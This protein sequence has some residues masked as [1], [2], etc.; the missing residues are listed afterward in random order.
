MPYLSWIWETPGNI[1][2]PLFSKILIL[3]LNVFAIYTPHPTHPP[4]PPFGVWT[5]PTILYFFLF[6]KI[7]VIHDTL[8]VKYSALL[9]FF[10][11]LNLLSSLYCSCCPFFFFLC[12]SASVEILHNH[13]NKH[14][15]N[16]ETNKQKEGDEVKKS[17]LIV[18]LLR[19]RR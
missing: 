7:P 6:G 9:T 18:V 11:I 2:P 3:K 8:G 14:V 4:P 15:E 1:E 5:F 13:S 16:K 10:A 17:P 12:R 19:L